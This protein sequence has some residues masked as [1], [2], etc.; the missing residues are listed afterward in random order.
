[1]AALATGYIV[2]CAGSASVS[3]LLAQG[4]SV[5][6]WMA[7]SASTR[8]LWTAEGSSNGSREAAP[9]DGVLHVASM[10]ST[11]AA[12]GCLAGAAR[13]RRMHGASGRSCKARRHAGRVIRTEND[14]TF[15]L[16]LSD[17]SVAFLDAFMA[18]NAT[19]VAL[20]GIQRMEEKPDEPGVKY[21]FMAPMDIGPYR[22]QMRLTAR[23]QPESGRCAVQVLNMEIGTVDK[24]TGEVTYPKASDQ[25]PFSFETENVI[26][27]ESDGAGG[28]R[29]VNV[30]KGY[31]EVTLPWWFPLPDSLVKAVVTAGVRQMVTQGQAKVMQQLQDRFATWKMRVLQ[32]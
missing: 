11:A 26:T 27:W 3:F 9:S 14:N 23:V 2:R 25:T 1:M 21:C 22:S 20:Q 7:R 28:L 5:G 12:V 18:E 24:K 15:P 29:V 8:Q 30:S 10:A 19:D 31:S 4:Q 6:S 16:S 13:R 17:S 32:A